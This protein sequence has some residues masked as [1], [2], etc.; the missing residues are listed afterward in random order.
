MLVVADPGP[1]MGADNIVILMVGEEQLEQEQQ[2]D[3]LFYCVL[4]NKY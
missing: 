4:D 3:K 2:R 1:V